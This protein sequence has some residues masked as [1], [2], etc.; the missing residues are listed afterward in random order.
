VSAHPIHGRSAVF[1]APARINLIG[2]HI[3]YTQGRV[4]PAS[5]VLGTRV[6]LEPRSEP[7]L[8]LYSTNLDQSIVVPLPMASQRRRGHWSDYVTGVAWALEQ[9]GIVLQGAE[10]RISSDVPLGDGLASSAA[11]EVAS[12]LALLQRA[13]RELPAIELALACVRAESDWVGARCGPMDQLIALCGHP[14][15]ARLIDCAS[16]ESSAIELPADAAWILAGTRVH[17]AHIGG[18]YNARR[19]ESEQLQELLR[20]RMG[21]SQMLR[22][23]SDAQASLL[24][25]SLSPTL[26]RRLRHI[27]SENHRVLAAVA[28]LARA[29]LA[30]LGALLTASHRSLRDDYEVSCPELETMVQIAG[31]LPGVYGARLHGGGFGGCALILAAAEQAS[32]VSDIVRREYVRATGI[33]PWMHR[34]TIGGAAGRIE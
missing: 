13:G 11:L 27:V 30:A 15:Q 10:L 34:C 22:E 29:D 18:E 16:F 1:F 8:T 4:L 20:T 7:T 17:H 33:E 9:L 2:E 14:N 21:E 23:L 28:A 3:D 32:T 24:I 31:A 19:R 6:T 26:A 25:D 12:A 5:L